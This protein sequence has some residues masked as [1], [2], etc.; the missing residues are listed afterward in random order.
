M[1]CNRIS[2]ATQSFAF[3]V[4]IVAI[5]TSAFAEAPGRTQ[6]A[7]GFGRFE[8]LPIEVSGTKVHPTVLGKFRDS[9]EQ[10]VGPTLATWN[11]ESRD[12]GRD[13]ALGVRVTLT[14]MRFVTGAKRF[15]IGP[16]AGSSHAAGTVT[17]VDL[18][19]GEALASESFDSASGAWAGT[20]TVGALD[21]RMIRT[22]ASRM[23]GYVN[24]CTTICF[25]DSRPKR[26]SSQT[27][28]SP[29]ALETE[30]REKS[31]LYK[32]LTEL[33]ELRKK[34]ILSE[35]EFQTEKEEILKR[36]NERPST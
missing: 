23:A 19:S 5:G 27:T 1:K 30:E 20:A 2:R 14:D 17:F 32:D 29:S 36:H 33:D 18:D 24:A 31:D 13:R 10:Q 28:D 22:L 11:S 35:E 15:W 26:L 21:N 4:G 7:N 25:G 9:L 34:E 12:S 8:L 6:S 16:I 3:A